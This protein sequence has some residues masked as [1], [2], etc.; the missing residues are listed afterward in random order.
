MSPKTYLQNNRQLVMIDAGLKNREIL[1][2]ALASGIDVWPIAMGSDIQ[3]TLGTALLP[4][5]QSISSH[6][7]KTIAYDV[8]KL[9]SSSCFS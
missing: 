1:L 7:K 8:M 2:E 5:I 9:Y 3:E 4:A 6:P